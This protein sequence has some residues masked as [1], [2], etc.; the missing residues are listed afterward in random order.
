MGVLT[1]ALLTWR[2]L[3]LLKV[4]WL[5]YKK[6]LP[7]FSRQWWSKVA[8]HTLL[9]VFMWGVPVSGFFFSNSFKGQNVRF[10]GI[11]L[12]DLFP[13]ND[14][15]VGLGRNLHF[16]LSYAF[17]SL[18]LLHMLERRKVVKANWRRF[19]GFIKAKLSRVV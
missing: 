8:L 9:Y 2:I 19:S 17:L 16:W 13:Q 18:I 12:P 10:F 14:A 6:R 4:F 3:V 15:L 5:K 1:M 7:K 11:T